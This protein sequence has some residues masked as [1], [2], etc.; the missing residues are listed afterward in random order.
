VTPLTTIHL[1]GGKGKLV[2][3]P[4]IWNFP[5]MK[6]FPIEEET[7]KCFHEEKFQKKRY[8]A[9]CGNFSWNLSSCN[10]LVKGFQ[11]IFPLELA[12]SFLLGNS[13]Q[14]LYH[15]FAAAGGEIS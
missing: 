15:R 14:L 9:F 3:I 13:C 1:E 7:N 6:A 8:T 11:E 10:R 2:E 4:F 12:V 5:F